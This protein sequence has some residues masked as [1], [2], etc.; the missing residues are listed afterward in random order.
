M[1]HSTVDA[2]QIENGCR[3]RWGEFS[4]PVK[5]CPEMPFLDLFG[6]LG[7]SWKACA[8]G[9]NVDEEPLLG[10]SCRPTREGTHWTS[11]LDVRGRRNPAPAASRDR[12]GDKVIVMDIADKR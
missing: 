10:M 5:K 1:R 12:H 2:Q 9:T 3:N 7:C 11:C 6:R 8:H 4:K